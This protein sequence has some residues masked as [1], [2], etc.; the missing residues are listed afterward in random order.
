ML[1]TQR[2]EMTESQGLFVL[3][4]KINQARWEKYF[5]LQSQGARFIQELPRSFR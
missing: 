3:K 5:K 2:K 1:P 4:N